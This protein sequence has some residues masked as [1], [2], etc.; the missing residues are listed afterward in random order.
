MEPCWKTT[1]PCSLSLWF[2]NKM[3]LCSQS[4]LLFLMSPSCPRDSVRIF[5]KLSE[6]F[7]DENN[8]SLSR[9]LLIKVRGAGDFLSGHFFGKFQA[10]LVW[11]SRREGSVCSVGRR[12]AVWVTEHCSGRPETKSQRGCQAMGL[13]DQ[14]D[15]GAR[16]VKGRQRRCH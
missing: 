7:S 9:E 3:R 2:Q 12:G 14:R 11:T 13:N 6:I 15:V 5:Q 4:P 10:Y 1:R 16:G 8:Y